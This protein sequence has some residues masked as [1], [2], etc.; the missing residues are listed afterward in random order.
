MLSL[1]AAASAALQG[2]L[3]AVSSAKTGS[4]RTAGDFCSP[5]ATE[6]FVVYKPDVRAT[7]SL[8]AGVIKPD[9]TLY[10]FDLPPSWSEG[11]ILNIL[12][13]NFCMPRCDEPWYETVWE[14]KDEGLAQL[15]VSP[16]YR[17]VSKSNA[18]LKDLGP[19]EQ[20][21]ERVGPFITGNYLDSIE[22][23]V[24]M[25]TEQF[26]DGRTY[27][28]YELVTPYAKTG[29]H[30]LSALT[31]KVRSFSKRGSECMG[32]LL[33]LL[34]RVAGVSLGGLKPAR[35]LFSDAWPCACR[36]TWSTYL[37]LAG[38]KLSGRG[39]SRSCDTCSSPSA[40]DLTKEEILIP[41]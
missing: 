13:G 12:S 23:A 25:G 8:R 34:F 40:L 7:P 41:M 4:T 15:V 32:C 2:G 27:Y 38:M 31:I 26:D 22:D 3:P 14:S 36:V 29:S 39:L 21:L 35:C 11:T 24:A 10:S 30:L 17:L 33:A 37:W 18:T 9:P 20:V 28:T 16:L 1:A 5:S 19:P 6:G